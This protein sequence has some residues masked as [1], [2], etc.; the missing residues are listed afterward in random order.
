MN[1][2]ELRANQNLIDCDGTSGVGRDAGGATA[3]SSSRRECRRGHSAHTSLIAHSE[4]TE[5]LCLLTARWIDT[6][7]AHPKE[8]M[9]VSST[10]HAVHTKGQDRRSRRLCSTEPPLLL[11]KQRSY[12]SDTQQNFREV[13]LTGR[14]MICQRIVL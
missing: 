3:C 11:V 10:T 2:S 4:D 5:Y 12:A 13:G 8:L 1:F 7:N 9:G 14:T 6:K